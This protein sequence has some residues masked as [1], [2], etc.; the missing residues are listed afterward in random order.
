MGSKKG[1]GALIGEAIFPGGIGGAIG[2]SIGKNK[3]DKSKDKKRER[4]N[5]VDSEEAQD[6]STG[7]D[8]PFADTTAAK[9]KKA[10]T[11]FAGSNVGALSGAGNSQGAL[12][13]GS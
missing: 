11:L 1:W 13:L 2:Y 6:N 4:M 10:N 8:D 12:T 3:D 9:K 7:G 5:A